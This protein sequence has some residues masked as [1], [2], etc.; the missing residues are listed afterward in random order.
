[1]NVP[2]LEQASE[3]LKHRF[4]YDSFRMNQEAA[5]SCVLSGGDCV[6]LMPTGGGKSLCYQIPALMLDGLTVVISP[7]IALMKDQVDSL[8]SNG[9]AAAFLNSTQ[10]AADQVKVFKSIRSGS[11]KLLYI[12]PERLLQNED[13]FIDFLRGINVSLFAVDEAHCISS[14][15]HDFRPEYI[16]LGRLKT[17][18]PQVPVIALTATADKLVRKDIVE[19]LHIDNAEIFRSSFNRPN[20][21][22]AIE[23]KQNSYNRLLDFL[24]ERK[25]ESGIIYCLSRASVDSLADDLQAEGYAALPYH[26]GLDKAVRDRHQTAFLNDEAKIIVATIAFGMGID[27]SNVRFV[28]HMDLPKNI[29]SYYQETGRAGRDGLQSNSLLFFSWGDVQKLQSFAAVDGN[30]QQT[31][32]M[33]RKLDQMAKYGDLK[34]CRRKFLLEYFSEDFAGRCGTCDNCTTKFEYFDG[35][36]IAQKA[37]SAVYRTGQRFGMK[38]IIDFLRGSQAKAIRDEHKQLKTYGIGADVPRDEWFDH[39]KELIDLGFLKKSDGEYPVLRLTDVSMDV[40]RGSTKVEL[41]KSKVTEKKIGLVENE[42]PPYIHELFESLRR[43]RAKLAK[44][45]NVP[46]YVVFADTS[47]IEMATYLPQN[48][49]EMKRISGVGDLKY[50]KYGKAFLDEIQRYCALHNLSSRMYL[51]RRARN[52]S[53]EKRGKSKG[54]T[55]QTS[56][57]MFRDGK[58]VSEIAAL[59]NLG[60]STIEGHLARFVE[61]GEIHLD[62]LVPVEKIAVIQKAIHESDNPEGWLSPIK[63]ILGDDYTYGEIRAVLAATNL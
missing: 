11:L 58:S 39:I 32:I 57:N 40:L 31:E 3:I 44:T 48:E 14:W 24:E 27:K 1:M 34:T 54:S 20:I 19:R 7:L 37:L 10:T 46:P 59:R 50:A 18:F 56:F 22:Y 21:F 49:I 38:Y 47:L 42:A 25:D 26:A 55:H 15:G 51:K 6:V 60:V 17:S 9:V 36:V 23:P 52:K 13:R 62:E 53:P 63:E 8:R 33:L 35:T 61:T 43:L 2:D 45:G 12:A 28:V 41:V 4:G 16:Q 29:E 5:I 30:P